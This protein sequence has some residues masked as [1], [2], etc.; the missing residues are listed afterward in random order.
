[1][2]KPYS[3]KIRKIAEQKEKVVKQLESLLAGRVDVYI[4][5]ANVRPWSNR[6]EW[7]IDLKRLN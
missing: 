6:L 3:G 4:D 2:F 7:H 1:M 5:Y